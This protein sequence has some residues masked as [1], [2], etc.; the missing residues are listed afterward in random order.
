MI[1]N[2]SGTGEGKR[3]KSTIII[4]NLVEQGKVKELNLLL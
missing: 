2:H 4:T 3:V 1:T